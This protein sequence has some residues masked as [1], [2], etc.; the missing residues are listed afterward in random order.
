M[1]VRR[2]LKRRNPINAP[3]GTPMIVLRIKAMPETRSESATMLPSSASPAK[4]SRK[5]SISP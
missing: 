1:A 2:P 4:I 3:K 5:A